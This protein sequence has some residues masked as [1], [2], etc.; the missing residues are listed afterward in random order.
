MANIFD[1]VHRAIIRHSTQPR[2]QGLSER[3]KLFYVGQSQ[4]ARFYEEHEGGTR[5][6]R[7][8]LRK[9]FDRLISQG[10]FLPYPDVAMIDEEEGL[11]A[12]L[13]DDVDKCRGSERTRLFVAAGEGTIPGDIMVLTG[14]I[15]GFRLEEASELLQFSDVVVWD[16][17]S[18]SDNENT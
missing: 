1:K 7:P 14:Q 13:G 17:M 15:G 5:K 11:C 12:M 6:I 2:I 16:V 4:L 9:D 18:L 8:G 3:A 10:F